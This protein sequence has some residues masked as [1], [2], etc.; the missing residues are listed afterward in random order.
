[1]PLLG[2]KV[3]IITGGGS[4]I[5]R[6]IALCFARE[7]A[8]VTIAGRSASSLKETLSELEGVGARAISVEAD[9][10]KQTDCKRMVERTIEAFGRIDV[11]VNNAGI[12]G[13]TKPTVDIELREWQEVIDTNLT[14]AWLATREVLPH[15]VRQG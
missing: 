13:P 7:G 4:G 1:M 3:A 9:V 8:R 12:A 5:G 11:L 2:D 14:G 10:S 15:M 6:E